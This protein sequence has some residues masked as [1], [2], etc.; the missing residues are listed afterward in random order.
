[1]K[2]VILGLMLLLSLT[3]IKAQVGDKFPEMDCVH[4]DGQEHLLLPIAKTEKFTLVGLA[5]SKKSEEAL[6]TWYK[7][8]YDKFI[9]KSTNKLMADVPYDLDLFFVPMFTG[10]NKAAAGTAAKEMK[11]GVPD[12]IGGHIL[13]FKG[14]IKEYKEALN[15]GNKDVPYFFVIDK[16]GNVAYATSGA[17]S[18]DKMGG[19]EDIVDEF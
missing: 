10:V 5:F 19:I 13:I 11:K 18:L 9:A 6:R 15:M 3:S 8:I 17:Y 1:M 14:N 7:P 12:E 4:L 2:K 16:S